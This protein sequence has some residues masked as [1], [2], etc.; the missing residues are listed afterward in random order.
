[1]QPNACSSPSKPFRPRKAGSPLVGLK[2][3]GPKHNTRP[4]AAIP[5]YS[6]AGYPAGLS[7]PRAPFSSGLLGL[8]R[9]EHGIRNRDVEPD[10]IVESL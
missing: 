6:S 8:R 4:A 7:L 9:R 1:M 2:D 5:L 3:L 10:L